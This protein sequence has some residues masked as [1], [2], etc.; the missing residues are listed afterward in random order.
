[1]S[2]IPGAVGFGGG[3]GAGQSGVGGENIVFADGS[4]FYLVG[5]AW[6]GSTHNPKR[7]ALV[8]AATKLF[9]RVHGHPAG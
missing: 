3:P 9:K 5:N 7:A 8:R 4:F 1:V 2:A 6:S